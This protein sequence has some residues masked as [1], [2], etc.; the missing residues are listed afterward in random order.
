MQAGVG[1]VRQVLFPSSPEARRGHEQDF[2]WNTYR[3]EKHQNHQT[4]SWL[5]DKGDMGRIPVDL[6]VL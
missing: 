6:L 2:Q 1:E 4:T 5:E 3:K